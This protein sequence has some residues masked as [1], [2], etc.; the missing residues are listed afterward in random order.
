[1]PLACIL[2][3]FPVNRPF[4]I[5]NEKASK[6]R[7]AKSWCGNRVSWSAD[8]RGDVRRSDHGVCSPVECSLKVFASSWVEGRRDKPGRTSR[9]GGDTLHEPNTGISDIAWSQFAVRR[10]YLK[11][12][13]DTDWHMARAASDDRRSPQ[14]EL[15]DHSATG[16]RS[17]S[18]LCSPAG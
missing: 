12:R 9:A 11:G 7:A 1:V 4:D 18:F 2:H 13:G 6:K 3:H 10:D 14:V 16:N 8:G 17:H 5:E 15:V